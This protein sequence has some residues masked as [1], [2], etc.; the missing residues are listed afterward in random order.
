MTVAKTLVILLAGLIASVEVASAQNAA[1]LPNRPIPYATLAKKPKPSA[2]EAKLN[3]SAKPVASAP[4]PLATTATAGPAGARLSP[5]QTLPPEQLEAFVDG[6]VRDAM[7][8]EHIAGVTLSV[9]QN[10]QIVLKKGYGA[11]NFSPLRRVNP[12]TTL[13]RLG[14]ISKTFTWIALMKEVE[15]GRIRIDGPINLYLPEK[16]QVKDQGYETR[17][18]VRNLMEHAA[19]FEDRALGQLIERD[20]NRE[21]TLMDYLRQERPRRIARPDAMASYSNYGA[22]LAGEA[23]S[24]SNGRPFE[25]LIEDEIINPLGLGHTTFRENRQALARLPAP[26][27]DSL[28]SD[29]S[30]GYF[31]SGSSYE[32][33]PYELIGHAGPAGA[34]SSTAGDMARYMVALLNDGTLDGATIYGPVAAKAFRTPIRVTPA[35]INGWRHGFVEYNLPGGFKGFGHPGATLSF[36]SNM[37][38]VPDLKLG[39]FISTN[40]DTGGSLSDRL[41]QRIVEQFYASP[42]SYPRVGNP[43]LYGI[44]SVY[45]GHYLGSRRAYRGLEAFVGR[46]TNSLTVEITKDGR[47]LTRSDRVRSWTPEG[48]PAKG[49]FISD[50][51]VEHLVFAISNGR[52]RTFV[53]ALN[54]QVYERAALWD[55]PITVLWSALLTAGA[56]LATLAGG[57][58]RNRRDF[59]ETSIQ[60]RAGLIQG[61]QAILWITAFLLFLV[62]TTKTGDASAVMYG[63]PGPIIL[64]SSACAVA[65]AGFTVLSALIAP[66]VLKGGRRVDSWT[67][68]RKF[69]YLV[70]VIIFSIFVLLLYR[71]GALTPWVS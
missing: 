15:A 64:L 23:V 55:R 21:R 46:L 60:S 43:A 9:V 17:V 71:W 2:P 68:P 5:G 27:P 70:T 54:T 8:R 3:V 7:D 1:P 44:R 24:Y 14:S 6:L 45:E 50:N 34:A 32:Q 35:G 57:L 30:T 53:T 18:T 62:W 36:M 66:A 48:D 67:V 59:R 56:S 26:M 28:K 20:P 42:T 39:V 13:F 19:G 65:S 29:L 38:M 33:R 37:V 11:A 25:R 40:T 47:L 61:L 22:A 16:L 58:V 69:G 52:A 12:D 31:W 63:W 51:G 41:A 49:R 4:S 10:G